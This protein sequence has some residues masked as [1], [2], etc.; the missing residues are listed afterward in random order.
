MEEKREGSN[1]SRESHDSDVEANQE[2]VPISTRPVSRV[3]STQQVVRRTTTRASSRYHGGNDGYSVFEE[4]DQDLE[5][6]ESAEQAFEVQ[7][8]GGDADPLNPRRMS[9][10][11]K[12]LIVLVIS[13]SSLC[14]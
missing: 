4:S 5:R 14:V 10:L 7:W 8:E 9:R 2:F 1:P 6:E 13:A 11:R 12:W 3:T